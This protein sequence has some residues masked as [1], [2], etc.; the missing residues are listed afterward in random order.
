MSEAFLEARDLRRGFRSGDTYLPVV[1]GVN[2]AVS[3]GEMVAIV[4]ASGVG[5]STLLHLLGTLDEPESGTV[6]IDGQDAFALSEPARSVLRNRT[7]GFVFQF[8]HLLPEFSAL[9][10][11]MMPLLV[12]RQPTASSRERAA[13]LLATLGL[14]ERASHR[15][16]QLSG[17]EQQ[18]VAVA[19]ALVA[20]PRLVLADEPTGNLDTRTSAELVRLLVRLHKERGLTS[21]L[22]THSEEIASS[23]DRTVY[24]EEG[25]IRE[26]R[27]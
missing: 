11:V 5:K 10:N 9:E 25:Q 21:V 26:S 1:K 14:A 3:R 27:S 8:H 22:V 16:G 12:A 6:H 13:E 18:R 24:M 20:E 4:G 23:C 2:F 7:I 19:R 17:G 15:P